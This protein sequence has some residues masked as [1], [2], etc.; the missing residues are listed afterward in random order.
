MTPR[1]AETDKKQAMA[2]VRQLLIAAATQEFAQKGFDGA[3][4]NTISLNAG[5]AK[6]T[7]YNYFP[8]KMDLMFAILEESGSAHFDFIAGQIRTESD[9]IHRVERFF[10]A[11]FEFVEENPAR[12]QVLVSTLYG[13][14]AEF[15]VRLYQIYQPMFQ[16]VAEEILGPG[17][18]Q[19][20]FHQMEPAATSRMIMT[21]Y[22][23][24]ASSVDKS[25]KLQLDPSE[26]AKF[27]LSAIR[28]TS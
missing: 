18:I 6:G 17:F 27:V 4:V 22:L 23:G 3:N 21:F 24:T 7:I 8:S 12:A 19:G 1:Y 2:G 25:G 26:V 14:H 9:P 13:T 11:G 16:L 20:V 10:K 15:K 5:F 28:S